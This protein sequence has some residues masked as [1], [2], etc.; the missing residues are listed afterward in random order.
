MC[1]PGRQSGWPGSRP[2]Q[3]IFARLSDGSDSRAG[4]LL[5]VARSSR[6]RALRQTDERRRGEQ[7]KPVEPIHLA[8]QAVG[9]VVALL[10]T[11]HFISH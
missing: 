8:I 9:V 3:V 6:A 11:P 2:C 1:D 7:Q 4:A 10:A 5:Q